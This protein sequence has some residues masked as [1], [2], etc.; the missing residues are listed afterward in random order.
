MPDKTITAKSTTLLA[1][2]AKII[3]S[4]REVYNLENYI[5]EMFSHIEQMLSSE[6]PERL[7]DRTELETFHALIHAYTGIERREDNDRRKESNPATTKDR[8]WHGEISS[9]TDA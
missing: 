1:L 2:E 6:K 9:V 7:L 5:P 4:G 8:R 3:A